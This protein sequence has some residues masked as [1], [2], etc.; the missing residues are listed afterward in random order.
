MNIGN[1]TGIQNEGAY[2]MNVRS[3]TAVIVERT[4]SGQPIYVSLTSVHDLGRF[5]IAALSLGLQSWPPEYRMSGERLTV[6]QILQWAAAV[7][8]SKKHYLQSRRQ[9]AD[10]YSGNVCNR[11]HRASRS[12]CPSSTCHLLPRLPESSSNSRADCDRAKKI[13]F[14]DAKSQPTRQ[15]A[16]SLIL[17][18]VEYSMG[19]SASAI[20]LLL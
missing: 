9:E 7:R 11:R 4:T 8:G 14:C 18:L 3:G 17:E 13:R 16:T 5:M 15:C 12:C 10:L 2:L 19:T 6:T 1:S 20:K